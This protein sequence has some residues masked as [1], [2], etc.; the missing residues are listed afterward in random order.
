MR[1]V[2]FGPERCWIM[3]QWDEGKRILNSNNK[4]TH[5][6]PS[7]HTQVV[8]LL[9]SSDNNITAPPTSDHITQ[10][11]SGRVTFMADGRSG[12]RKQTTRQP[13]DTQATRDGWMDDG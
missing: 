12:D 2:P 4:L 3:C 5:I 8:T 10:I 9:S 6:C 13:G 1:F 7:S 11:Q